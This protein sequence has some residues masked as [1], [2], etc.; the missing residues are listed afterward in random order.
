MKKS[1]PNSTCL[2][3]VAN[4]P[5]TISILTCTEG[6]VA[7]KTHRRSSDGRRVT[8]AFNAG[9]YFDVNVA[10]FKDL[11]G[12]FEIIIAA[13]GNPK[14]FVIRGRLTEDAERDQYGHVRRTSRKQKNGEGPSFED[15]DCSWVMIDFDKVDNPE[16]LDPTS[17]EG[18]GY[19]RS[20]LPPEFWQVVCIYSL[21]RTPEQ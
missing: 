16:G 5:H 2:R 1:I 15:V 8:D 21:L 14:Q 3:N 17:V 18:M 13:A 10:T 19:L 7:A 6:N 4:G 11:S 20:L 9:K 12:L